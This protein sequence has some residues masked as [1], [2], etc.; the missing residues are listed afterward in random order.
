PINIFHSSHKTDNE[1]IRL[2]YHNNIHYNSVINPNKP[3]VGVG[4]GISGYK[5][6][7]VLVNDAFK[8]SEEW[9]IEQQML[10]D[11]LRATDWEATDE[12]MEEA[13]ARESYL[14]W[15]QDSEK[16]ARG[17]RAASSRKYNT[18]YIYSEKRANGAASSRKYN[19]TYIYSEK[20]A[21]GA[22]TWPGA[23]ASSS[24]TSTSTES[25]RPTSPHHRER[26]R[27]PEN[28]PPSKSPRHSPASTPT[29]SW[30][31]L[32]GPSLP[33]NSP[34]VASTST[35]GA[36]SVVGSN[37][38]IIE[39]RPGCSTH[40]SNPPSPQGAEGGATPVMPNYLDFIPK[41]GYGL[42]EW[43]DER[44]LA[45]VLAESQKDYLASLKKSKKEKSPEPGT[46]SS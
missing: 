4:L 34:S 18:T 11:K 23:T 26:D 13:V 9:H 20:R 32:P 35:S 8:Q 21:N 45:V 42:S 1:P 2:S 5:P 7:N 40:I 37:M 3:S 33:D 31:D 27:D 6:W 16:R 39:P 30:H 12:A 44:I 14:D 22:A 10:E 43:E 28:A 15:L 17:A 46:H 24:S 41:S 29:S 36:S 38:G 19:T 25:K